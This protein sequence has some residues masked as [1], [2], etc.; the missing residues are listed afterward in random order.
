[1]A[2]STIL[3]ETLLLKSIILINKL[4]YEKGLVTPYRRNRLC[5]YLDAVPEIIDEHW[6]PD[7]SKH[8]IITSQIYNV[9]QIPAHFQYELSDFFR[10]ADII[11]SRAETIVATSKLLYEYACKYNK[12]VILSHNGTAIESGP[13]C[14]SHNAPAICP[15]GAKEKYDGRCLPT[16]LH[17]VVVSNNKISSADKY[18]YDKAGILYS[19]KFIPA[20]EW[21]NYSMVVMN[22][23]PGFYNECQDN[24]KYYDGIAKGLPLLSLS[25]ATS[26][27]DHPYVFT[28]KEDVRWPSM[29]EVNYYRKKYNWREVFKEY[30][31]ELYK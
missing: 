5:A 6:L 25:S 17:N 18:L 30:A 2:S 26:V 16:L 14:I 23:K 24:L 19:E 10:F 8:Y 29:E 27:L 7:N 4:S 3:L 28:K 13:I 31:N 15:Y 22:S 21:H 9:Q 12:N 11:C 1:M 20:T